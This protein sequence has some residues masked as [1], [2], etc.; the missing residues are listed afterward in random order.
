MT[1]N[2]RK[3]LATG[4]AAAAGMVFPFAARAQSK[5]LAGKE[6]K[7][8][9]VQATQFAAHE[10]RAAAFAEQTGAKVTYVYVPFAALRE[11]LTS[12]MAGN[13]NDFDVITAMDVWIPPMMD[14]YLAPLDKQIA[15]AKIDMERYPSAFRAAGK[16]PNG[17]YG[18]PNRC[19]IQLLWY[20]K[21]LFEK[22]GLKEPPKTWD[23]LV[24]HGLKVQAANPGIA[25]V[26]I[27]Y[28]KADG[29]NL[30]VWYNFLWGAGGDLF[31]ANM[32]PIFNSAAAIKATQDFVDIIVKHKITPVGAAGFNEA[33]S[34]TAF[35]QG[36]AA[37][38][39]VWWHVYNRFKLPDAQV[40]LD[41]VGFVPLPSYPGKGP[42]TYTNQW[43]YGLNKNSRNQDAAFAFMDFISKPEIERSILLDPAENDVVCV[44]WN[45][46]RDAEINKRFTGMHGIA[47]QALE[48]TKNAIPNIP[49]FLPIVDA[50]STAMSNIVTA[51]GANIKEQLD[52]A[53]SQ[54]Q[55]IMR[56]G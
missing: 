12:E 24:Q 42:T 8:L 47:A 41:Q 16:G 55:R 19:H 51:N 22:A 1:I 50:L 40:K 38:V 34:T 29:Q 14:R 37:M 28:S 13:S 6:I 20:R 21:D 56:R 46:L 10:K 30:M 3:V 31:D 25:G 11:R 15:A 44:H 4:A 9:S 2:R 18:L 33:D 17:I 52:Q 5:P 39:P 49:E 36:R 53:V 23:E 26:T 45:N 32:R 48:T 54:A 35:F 7:V 43:I 27:P